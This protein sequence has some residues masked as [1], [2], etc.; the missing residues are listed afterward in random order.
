[1]NHTITVATYNICHGH[2]AAFDWT[3]IAEPIRRV[4]ADLVGIQEVDMFTRRSKGIDTLRA[5]SEAVG[6]PYTLFVPT[7]EYD[8]GRYG[9]AILSRYPIEDSATFA[10][11]AEGLEPRAVGCIRVLPDGQHPLWLINTHLSYKSAEVRHEQLSALCEALMQRIPADTPAI[12]TGDFNTEERLVPVVGEHFSDINESLRYKTFRDPAIA[13]DRIVY[14]HKNLS[15][16][17][18]GM[19]ESD[20]SDHH[21]LWC[22]L[23]MQ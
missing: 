3:R 7:M 16:V 12:L 22:R 17:A 6:L 5:L 20:A 13:I 23:A 10:L 9:T 21:L 14:T 19:I 1:M 4:N 8:G 18:D 11:P 15:P 2:Y